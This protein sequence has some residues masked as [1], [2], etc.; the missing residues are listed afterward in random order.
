MKLKFLYVLLIIL[1]SIGIFVLGLGYGARVGALREMAVFELMFSENLLILNESNQ[2]ACDI[3]FRDTVI[4]MND[5]TLSM[6]ESSE[7]LLQRDNWFLSNLNLALIAIV[8]KPEIVHS[9]R[10]WR[11]I[12]REK[13][14]Q[15]VSSK[16]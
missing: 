14:K 7:K 9:N 13:I 5:V 2:N 3:E 4:S 11:A 1:M 10:E 15:K 8:V 16:Y 6:H 12:F